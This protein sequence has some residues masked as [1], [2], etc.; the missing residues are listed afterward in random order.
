MGRRFDRA[1]SS[2][3]VADRREGHRT[4]RLFSFAERLGARR[5]P[6][7]KTATLREDTA[8]LTDWD[9]SRSARYQREHTTAGSPSM[10]RYQPCSPRASST[11]GRT[12]AESRLA[13]VAAAAS[14]A[15]LN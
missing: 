8:R 15:A 9:R 7:P 4:R 1:L 3:F 12:I 14:E 13:T 2:A 11:T 6:S 5:A 10:A